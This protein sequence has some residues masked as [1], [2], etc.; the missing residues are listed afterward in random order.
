MT[1]MT[2]GE[3]I[4]TWKK[5]GLISDLQYDKLRE[6]YTG[7]LQQAIDHYK[8][9]GVLTDDQVEKLYGQYHLEGLAPPTEEEEAVAEMI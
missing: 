2:G 5:E 3:Q 6:L 1:E 9:Y 4:E 7:D 8:D